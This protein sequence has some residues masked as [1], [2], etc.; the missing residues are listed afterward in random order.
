MDQRVTNCKENPTPIFQTLR[1]YWPWKPHQ[2][3][4]LTNVVIWLDSTLNDLH[5][6]A[7]NLNADI[8]AAG[9]HVPMCYCIAHLSIYLGAP[10]KCWSRGLSS[11]LY[12]SIEGVGHM[13]MV[14]LSW[15]DMADCFLQKKAYILLLIKNQSGI[16]GQMKRHFVGCRLLMSYVSC[17]W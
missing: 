10:G 13:G 8:R 14:D 12:S 5:N 16:E 1:E 3:S 2:W 7:K 11:G 9:I 4:P 15:L 17:K 6:T